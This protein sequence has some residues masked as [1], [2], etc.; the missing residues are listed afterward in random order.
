MMSYNSRR[1]GFVWVKGHAAKVHI[2]QQIT[3]SLIK[4]GTDA[5]D[6][7]ASA[8]AAFHAAPQSWTDAAID[9]QRTALSCCLE[10]E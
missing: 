8:G 2:D 3:T 10:D 7:L 6:A 1:L 5:A 4:G 9:R